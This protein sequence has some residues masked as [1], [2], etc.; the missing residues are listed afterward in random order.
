[1]VKVQELL[2]KLNKYLSNI[3]SSFCG[4]CTRTSEKLW[5]YWNCSV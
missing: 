5:H 2:Q 4:K 3:L 1:M